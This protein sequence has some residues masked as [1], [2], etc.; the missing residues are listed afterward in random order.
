MNDT[1]HTQA[2]NTA[3][4]AI[5]A[6]LGRRGKARDPEVKPL[7]PADMRRWGPG[8]SNY[9]AGQGKMACPVCGSGVLHYSRA[10]YNGHVHAFCTTSECVA[11]RE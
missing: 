2:L 1:E 4:S 5:V 6:E 8:H 10:A 7:D 3:R 11:W 9:Y